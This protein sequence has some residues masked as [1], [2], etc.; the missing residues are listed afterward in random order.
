MKTT[1]LPLLNK[2]MLAT[3]IPITIFMLIMFTISGCSDTPTTTDPRDD[4][5]RGYDDAM[6]YMGKGWVGT[7]GSIED[8]LD[9]FGVKHDKV[10]GGSGNPDLDT[11]Y[12]IGVV[13]AIRKKNNPDSIPLLAPG[14]PPSASTLVY[15]VWGSSTYH[16]IT[17]R[18]I[19]NTKKPT[20]CLFNFPQEKAKEMGLKCC[21]TCFK[22]KSK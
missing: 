2:I 1:K 11:E 19:I 17:C 9:H 22:V 18:F 3:M 10:G 13:D 4:Y 8:V 16:R 12:K 15:S 7:D 14:I 6:L 5:K 21:S 20:A